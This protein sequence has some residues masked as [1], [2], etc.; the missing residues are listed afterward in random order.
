MKVKL[1]KSMMACVLAFSLTAADIAPVFAAEPV[2]SEAVQEAQED[3][4]AEEEMSEEETA[5]DAAAVQEIVPAETGSS[6][7]RSVSADPT[8]VSVS[9]LTISEDRYSGYVLFRLAY[10]AGTATEACELTVKNSG[11]ALVY[12]NSY[13]V[14][15]NE[16]DSD[17][18]DSSLVPGAAYTFVL[19]PFAT[20]A[21]TEEKIYG[22]EKSVTWT[23]PAPSINQPTI[24]A[25]L[26]SSYVSFRLN[27]TGSD[28]EGC[29]LDVTVNGVNVYSRNSYDSGDSFDS[30]D[31]YQNLTAGARYT[32][33]LTPRI[34]GVNGAPK[35][36]TWTA[37]SVPAVTGLAVKEMTP[38]GFVFT[39]GAVPAN[40]DVRYEYADNAAFTDWDS[41]GESLPYY[42]LDMGVTYY[43]R[44]YA[45]SAGIKGS[46]SN[47]VTVTAPVAEV[48]GIT[49]EITDTAVTLRLNAGYGG[50]TGFEI[51]RKIG[52]KYQ[53]L[54]TVSDSVFAD[55]GLEKDTA[56]KY[57]VRAIYYNPNTK[58]T[59]YGDYAYKTVKTGKA[60]MNLKAE[61]TGKNKIQLKWTKISG[62]SGYE[63]Y[64]KTGFSYN[65]TEKSGENYD[66]E[67]YE[68]IKNLSKKK[69]SYTDKKLTAG[70]RYTYIVRA[71]KLVKGKKQYFAEASASADTK[72]SF[73][74]SIEIYKQAQNPKNG[75]MAIAWRRIPQA[76]GYLIEKEDDKGAWITLA[77]LKASKT[78]YTLPASPAGK[79]VTYRVRA[80]KGNKYSG[81][82]T[83][84]VTGHIAAVTGVKAAAAA[85]GVRV[86]WNA[87]PG[88]SYYKVY[89]TKSS[90]IFYDA[91]TKTYG[92]G[93]LSIVAPMAFKAASATTT[94]DYYTLGS[95]AV[96]MDRDYDAEKRMKYHYPND[97]NGYGLS[98]TVVGTSVMDYS[99][100]YHSFTG[101]G[102][103]QKHNVE[104]SGPQ[105]GVAY[106]YVV[107]AYGV[108]RD[109]TETSYEKYMTATS[110]GAS[111]DDDD[112]Y[113]DYGA[114]SYGKAASVVYAG[115]TAKL[116]A[117][118]VKAKA[119]KKSATLTIGKVANASGYV[120]YRSMK[121]KGAYQIVGVT[122]KTKFK[123]SGLT[124]K[125]KYYYKV[126]AV[127]RN[128]IGT[129]MYSSFSKVKNIKAK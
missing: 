62:A 75:T 4:T 92:Y 40:T 44:A 79:S 83:V 48:T 33:T 2:Q 82:D 109:M 125:K 22:E 93:N 117:P 18:F 32:F 65:M 59:T 103:A 49:T 57:R 28:Y 10:T 68:L 3:V 72:F 51:S 101:T 87:V 85:D 54:A 91:D 61:A 8:E 47:V 97:L 52:K 122:T 37:P 19:K 129:D 90:S 94:D 120:I 108:Q 102:A 16:I 105:A 5:E 98:N 17:N 35:S 20:D 121:K 12:T 118:S 11:G 67:K 80:Y 21:A 113:Y 58:K 15:G 123:D 7:A 86:S 111:Y 81:E 53:K 38:S 46:Y 112:D 110:Y 115:N 114:S 106:N 60:A 55:K 84:R 26:Y 6:M 104:L 116:K 70:E 31:F 29:R 88:A 124:K 127:G 128:S 43:V 126:K 96:K 73:S 71:Y 36:A 64:R 34:G 42:N 107:V 27:Y 9:G 41:T 66:F 63:V 74:R 56:Y 100:S 95:G 69:K 24:S 99:C 30:D 119:G 76:G 45:M 25:T 77:K 39:H 1:L 78:T 13:Y 23:A 14:S 89:R 50:Y